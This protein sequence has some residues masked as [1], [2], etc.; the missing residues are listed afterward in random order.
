[1][2]RFLRNVSSVYSFRRSFFRFFSSIRC[3]RYRLEI[4]LLKRCLTSHRSWS[5]CNRL[6]RSWIQRTPS[7]NQVRVSA[8]NPSLE[9]FVSSSR[10]DVGHE[11]EPKFRKN[12]PTRK[13][14]RYGNNVGW[15]PISNCYSKPREFDETNVMNKHTLIPLRCF[16]SF[17]CERIYLHSSVS[18]KG[19]VLVKI[20]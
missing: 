15:K 1:M 3:R 2:V 6:P 19:N 5:S 12:L 10:K 14:R 9:R 13:A 11:C 17:F 4:C 16:S 18:S 7:T 20:Y 8:Y